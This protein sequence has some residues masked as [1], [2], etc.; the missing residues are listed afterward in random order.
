MTQTYTPLLT[1]EE[2]RFSQRDRK[3]QKQIEDIFNCGI[4]LDHYAHG[5]L[6]S[7]PNTPDTLWKGE[8]VYGISSDDGVG[9]IGRSDGLLH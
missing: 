6:G 8:T 7:I 2:C 5:D 3:Q 9:E 4:S 1:M